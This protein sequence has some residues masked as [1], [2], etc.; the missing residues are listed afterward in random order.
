MG[1]VL[2]NLLPQ[3][4]ARRREK[5]QVFLAKAGLGALLT[6]PAALPGAHLAAAFTGG[7]LCGLL[8]GWRAQV[9]LIGLAGG[10]AVCAYWFSQRRKTRQEELVRQFPTAVDVICVAVGGGLDFTQAMREVSENMEEGPVRQEFASILGRV[11]LGERRSDALRAFAARVDAIEIR[12]FV[13]SLVQ[14][15][16]VGGAGLREALK[17]QAEQMRYN[18]LCRAEEAANKAPSKMVIPM[19]LFIVPC[20]FLVVF[21]PLGIQVVETFRG[22]SGN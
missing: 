14:T 17:V 9:L 4:M 10:A 12:A 1:G 11:S 18:R 21:V 7:A 5:D 22:M 20:I 16:E 19:I 6:D 3:W 8:Y 15:I 13:T 2:K